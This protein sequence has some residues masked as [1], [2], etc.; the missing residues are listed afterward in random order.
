VVIGCSCPDSD[1]FFPY[2]FALGTDSVR[3]IKRFVVLD[4][5]DQAAH[6]LRDMLGQ[7]SARRF[8]DPFVFSGAIPAIKSELGL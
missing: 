6:R 1:A 3:R 8:V 2:R 7:D 4:P 5:S